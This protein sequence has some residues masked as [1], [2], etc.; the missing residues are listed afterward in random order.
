MNWVILVGLALFFAA[1]AMRNGT[2]WNFD[3]N[4]YVVGIDSAGSPLVVRAEGDIDLAPDASGVIAVGDGDYLD[5]RET[6]AAKERRAR[7]AGVD[8]EIEKQFWVNGSEQP[9]GADA[10]AFVA[11]FMPILLRETTISVEE[12]VA[13]LLANRGQTG[14]LDEIDLIRS[15]FA[16]RVYTIEYSES[17]AIAAPDFKRLMQ[18]AENNMG[19]DFDLRTALIAVHGA[20]NPTGENLVALIGAAKSIGSD[21]DAR[22]LLSAIGSGVLDTPEAGTAYLDVAATIGSDFDIRHALAPLVTNDSV[23]DELVARA[24]DLAGVEIGSDFDLRVLLS[25]AAARVGPSDP[26]ATA[27]VNAV[28][29]I[30]SD[31]D[32]KEA[33]VALADNAELTPMGWQALLRSAQNIGGDF[34]CS[35]L[36]MA[37]AAKLPDDAAIIDAYEAALATIGGEFERRRAEGA[38]AALRK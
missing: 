30:G 15:D 34:E 29:S 23:P 22:V 33:L 26:L 1:T 5:V 27:Y 3:Q 6:R 10:D 7:F 16:Q 37:V 20:Q 12:R 36:L 8:G 14:L 21:F 4:G 18:S 2:S 17:G 28:Q 35:T 13:W 9:W 38:F 24:L 31:F 25:L 11:E 32:H 19:S